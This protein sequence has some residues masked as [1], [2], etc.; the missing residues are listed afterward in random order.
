[1]QEQL[2]AEKLAE[3]T[4]KVKVIRRHIIS[5]IF[6]A[7]SGHP[8]GSL[9]AGEILTS[10]YFEIMQVD[11]QNPRWD[12][13]D[14]FVL[15]KG[16]AAPVLYATL[17]ERGFFPVEELNS[18]R[19]INSRLQGHPDMKGTPGV[20]MSTGSLGQ[21]LSTANGMA[22]A[23]KMDG[24]AWRVYALMGDGEQQEGQVWEAAMAASHYKLD[25]LTAFVDNN[26]LQIDGCIN[27][28]M[29]PMPLTEKWAAFGWH[30]ISIDGHDIR[31]VF[32]AVAEA[33]ATKGKPT[34]IIASTTKGKGVC[35]MEN[36][37]DWHGKAPNQTELEQ[38][39][40]ELV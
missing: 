32:R 6:A 5:M 40:Q 26:G 4:N 16:H 36:V 1:M 8:G 34:V 25:N 2:S 22:L 9:S 18:L 33:K 39:L 12:E 28:V 19:R 30:V 13:R 35:A 10:L 27:Q 29:S 38:A 14:R 20:D 11:P 15:C 31:A 7:Q 3:L 37:A 24:K 17:A 23:G 21:G